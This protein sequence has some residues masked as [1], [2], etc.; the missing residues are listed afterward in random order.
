VSVEVMVC[1]GGWGG[2]GTSMRRLVLNEISDVE[3][4]AVIGRISAADPIK[5]G[6]L[7]MDK[8]AG[9]VEK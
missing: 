6:Q 9:S 2:G 1:W 7:L 4:D 5:G 3:L 8:Y